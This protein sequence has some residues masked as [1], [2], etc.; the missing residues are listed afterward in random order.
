[1][2]RKLGNTQSRRYLLDTS[3]C[4][5][6]LRSNENVIQKFKEVGLKSCSIT[7]L[8]IFEL[9]Y[10]AEINK[11]AGRGVKEY[12]KVDELINRINVISVSSYMKEIAREKMRLRKQGTPLEDFI[13]LAI[14]CT[15][16]QNNMTMVTDNTRHFINVKDVRLE[17]WVS[18]DALKN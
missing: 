5:H 3:I 8:T 11:D 1:M 15:S 6:L 18:N 2:G 13:D 14:A 7:D 9:Y 16:V 17:N 4:I 12:K 10:G